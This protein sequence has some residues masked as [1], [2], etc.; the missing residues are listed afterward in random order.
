M[1]IDVNSLVQKALSLLKGDKNLLASFTSDP[2]KTLKNI[3]GGDLPEDTIKQVIEGVKKALP[4]ESAQGILA[5][6]KSFLSKLG[7]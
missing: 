1:A 6:I 4:A 7:K 5:K 2:V 3:L